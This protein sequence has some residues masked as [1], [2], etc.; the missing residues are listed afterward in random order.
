MK[1]ASIIF[2]SIIL[3]LSYSCNKE[4][5]LEEKTYRLEELIVDDDNV[6]ESLD[7]RIMF[8]Y[9]DDKLSQF[10][11]YTKD[12]S[13]NWVY[14]GK[15]E[16]QYASNIIKFQTYR[17]EQ[18]EWERVHTVTF[19]YENDKLV[20]LNKVYEDLSFVTSSYTYQNQVLIRKEKNI[21]GED[22]Y[23]TNYNYNNN[24]LTEVIDKSNGENYHKD[25]FIYENT[26][27]KTVFHSSFINNEWDMKHKTDYYYNG[28]NLSSQDRI[29]WV[30]SE[31]ENVK[32]DT[33]T[34]DANNV[35]KTLIY[36]DEITYTFIS[37]EGSSNLDIFTDPDT[38]LYPQYSDYFSFLM[39]LNYYLF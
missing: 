37:K 27:M 19:N 25:D 13:E 4:D 21:N 11:Y 36:N 22:L 1:K 2:I 5:E 16:I 18:S 15:S 14:I 12:E 39:S 7:S 10:D 6:E 38:K 17:Y 33:F 29:Y 34:Y 24:L 30:G 35:L 9:D 28:D 20:L 3:T 31:M 26:K 23:D 32:T 8:F